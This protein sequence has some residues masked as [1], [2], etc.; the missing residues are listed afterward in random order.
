MNFEDKHKEFAVKCF[1]QYMKRADVV[2][3]FMEEFLYDI[4]VA[5]TKAYT[6]KVPIK[7]VEDL[8]KEII[9]DVIN[10]STYDMLERI[11]MLQSELETLIEMAQEGQNNVT[12]R[13]ITEHQQLINLTEHVQTYTK[14]QKNSLSTRL[15]RLDITHN[16]FPAKYRELFTKTRNEYFE[17][18]RGDKSNVDDKI[19]MELETLYGYVKDTVFHEQNPT[20]LIKHLNLAHNILKT[21]ATYNAINEKQQVIDVI[22]NTTEQITD[23]QKAITDNN[24]TN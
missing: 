19:V 2:K 17:Y 12:Q 24:Q 9:I 6:E 7:A 1:A 10:N 8:M 4:A 3:A 20:D 11:S 5:C 16:Q 14:E 15:R 21:I 22:P 23:T 13:H 18:Y